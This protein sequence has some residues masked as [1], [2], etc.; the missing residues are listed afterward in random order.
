MALPEDMQVV[1]VILFK[2]D[3]RKAEQLAR[4]RRESRSEY[5]RKLITTHPDFF[6]ADCSLDETNDSSTNHTAAA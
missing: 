2:K 6:S 4:A 1:P 3:V 5:L